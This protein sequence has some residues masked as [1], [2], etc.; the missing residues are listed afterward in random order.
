MDPLPR[1]SIIAFRQLIGTEAIS[2]LR[3]RSDVA[4]EIIAS[5][6]EV[7]AMRVQ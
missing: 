6:D 2:V 1:T 7:R 4:T 5:S 3:Y